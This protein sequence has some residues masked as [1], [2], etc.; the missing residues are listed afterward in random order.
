MGT[1]NHTTV[2]GGAT[3]ATCEWCEEVAS[4]RVKSRSQGYQRFACWNANHRART[5]KLVHIDLGDRRRETT[6]NPTGFDVKGRMLGP[7][8]CE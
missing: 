6:V 7:K 4:Y 2:T 8:G 3:C 1:V 5:D